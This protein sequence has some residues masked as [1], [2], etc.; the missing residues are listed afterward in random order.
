MILYRIIEHMKQRHWVGVC[1]DSP[2]KH[3]LEQ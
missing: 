1:S 3:R 2:P